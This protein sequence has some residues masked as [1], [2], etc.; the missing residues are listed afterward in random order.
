MTGP[1]SHLCKLCTFFFCRDVYCC[2]FV[3]LFSHSGLLL[4]F[5]K[6]EIRSVDVGHWTTL[7]TFPTDTVCLQALK[8]MKVCKVGVC[9]KCNVDQL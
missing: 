9:T 2:F 3:F 5:K 7:I 4:N 8:A 1:V 6:V